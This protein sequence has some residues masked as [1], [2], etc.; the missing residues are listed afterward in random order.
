MIGTV[1]RVQFTYGSLGNQMTTIEVDGNEKKYA[2]WWDIM[3]T[4]VKEGV[5]VE[6][7]ERGPTEVSL[8]GNA[9]II[10]ENVAKIHRVLEDNECLEKR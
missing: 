10:F 7:E 3:K 4:P 9:K 6:F 1:T 2:T 8:G 5:R